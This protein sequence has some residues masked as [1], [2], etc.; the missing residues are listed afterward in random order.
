MSKPYNVETALT[1][2]SLADRMKETPLAAVGAVGTIGALAYGL[3]TFGKSNSGVANASSMGRRVALQFG[4]LIAI[5][6][7]LAASKTGPFAPKDA[8]Q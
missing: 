6:G 8:D 2:A 4:T 7:Y 3:W 1:E 5:V